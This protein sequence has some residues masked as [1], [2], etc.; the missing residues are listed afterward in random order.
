[1]YLAAPRNLQSW[2]KDNLRLS[3]SSEKVAQYTDQLFHQLFGLY[4]DPE[5]GGP[6]GTIE[7]ILSLDEYNP[8]AHSIKAKFIGDSSS[9]LPQ[10]VVDSAVNDLNL[11][12]CGNFSCTTTLHVKAAKAYV[13][14][15][16]TLATNTW[17]DIL[18]QHPKDILSQMNLF[19]NLLHSGRPCEMY[20]L[21]FA[22]S[23][24]LNN[25]PY[26]A[27]ADCRQAFALEQMS[28][29]A[30]A[31]KLCYKS[32]TSLPWNPWTG[33]TM[34]H[35]YESWAKPEKGIAFYKDAPPHDLSS[36][37]SNI[38]FWGQNF[39]LSCHQFW[40]YSLFCIEAGQIEEALRVYD[41]EVITRA[42]LVNDDRFM[43]SDAIGFL[44]R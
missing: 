9:I 27:L 20:D 10:P 28:Q 39:Y 5:L 43:L 44:L 3:T 16:Y 18:I 2:S 25:S 26:Q 15:D 22:G 12:L 7:K 33:H 42:K 40:H 11:V 14:Q 41:D 24:A 37:N 38:E 17:R 30:A 36:A 31:E 32:Y 6:T 8:I 1:M 35:I 4:L 19:V 23:H 21:T 34:A 29:L 13:L